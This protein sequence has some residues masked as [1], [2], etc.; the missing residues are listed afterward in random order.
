MLKALRVWLTE[1]AETSVSNVRALAN[2]PVI[3]YDTIRT[4]EGG[5]GPVAGAG[6]TLPPV[7]G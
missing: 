3:F 1:S 7:S 4:F 2:P 5:V 6:A